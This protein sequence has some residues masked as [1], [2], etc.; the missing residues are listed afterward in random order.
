[1]RFPLLGKASALAAV[2][3]LL[4]LG[5]N[6]IDNVNSERQ[7]RQIEAQQSLVNALAGA[8]TVMGP[9]LQRH[10]RET[11]DHTEGEGAHRKTV[12]N[13]REFVLTAWPQSLE[14]KANA[15]I[16]PRYRGLFKLNSYLTAAEATAD[17]SQLSALQPRAEL[18]NGQVKCDA[19]V[20][21]V[22]V[23]D[24]R[25]IQSAAI[26]VGGQSL[27]LLPGS[28]LQNAAA[29]FHATLPDLATAPA[30][31]DGAAQ[32]MPL[33]LT[34]SLNLAGTHSVA[35]VPLADTT[36]VRLSSDWPHPSF[37]GRFLPAER[38][39][40]PSGFTAQWR[41]SALAT[42]AQQIAPAEALLCGIGDAQSG[43]LRTGYPAAIEAAGA[44]PN[45]TRPACLDS[46]GVSFIDPVNSYVLSDRALKYALLFIALTFV[47]VAL[48]EVMRSLRVHPVQ[49]LLV[50]CALSIFFLLLLSL[51]EHVAFGW[52]Y[53]CA[54][55]ACCGLLTFYGHH[56]LQSARA[57]WAFGGAIA[58]L[59]AALY[60][61][62]QMEQTAL[63]LG[64]LLLFMALTAVMVA[65]RRIDWYAL[66]ERLRGP[67]NEA[68]TGVPANAEVVPAQ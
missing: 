64:S 59:Y 24:A 8:Q 67:R 61:L 63:V 56:L 5:L 29:G 55:A 27:A 19:P 25:G 48:V 34:V 15:G 60:A 7:S 2:T 31:A 45:A 40:K 12:S 36:Q 62:L 39:V 17:W 3:A 58:L 30:A 14:V 1:M 35:W 49:Y 51:A 38:E 10:C 20:V 16:E 22:A 23:N 6:S 13:R 43:P 11:W 4:L 68:D 41:V 53:L 33:S 66:A 54:S 9:L 42:T 32:G 21:V 47:G 57:G 26:R 52:A 50:G 46:F 65:T 28:G 18:P 37:G 44:A